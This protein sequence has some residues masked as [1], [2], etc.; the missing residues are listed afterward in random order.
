[1]DKRIKD[2]KKRMHRVLA[3]NNTRTKKEPDKKSL[4]TLLA[5]EHVLLTE[6]LQATEREYWT[7]LRGKL[8]AANDAVIAEVNRVNGW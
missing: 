6:Y 5:A 8:K 2:I 4:I 1:M 3:G 7:P